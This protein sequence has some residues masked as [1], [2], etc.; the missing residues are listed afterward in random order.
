MD[1]RRTVEALGLAPAGVDDVLRA[2]KSEMETGM[3][4]PITPVQ[5]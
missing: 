2:L 4:Q 1:R 5:S 3:V